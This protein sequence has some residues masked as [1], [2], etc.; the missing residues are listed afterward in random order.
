MNAAHVTALFKSE[1]AETLNVIRV[2]LFS[3][4]AGC[5]YPRSPDRALSARLA[6]PSGAAT[7]E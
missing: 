1:L 6:T 2:T 5:T 3:N 7:E 4:F